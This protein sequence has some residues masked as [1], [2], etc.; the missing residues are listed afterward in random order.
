MRIFDCVI[1]SGELDL[2]ER[3]FRE[4][5]DIPEVTHVIAESVTDYKGNPK[6]LHFRANDDRFLPWLGRWNHVRVEAGELSGLPLERKEALRD[7]LSHGFNGEP[8]D[9]IM[10]SN[11]DEIPSRQAVRELAAGNIPLPVTLGMRWGED[12]W[13]GT[14]VQERQHTG[15]FAGLRRR[16]KDLPLLRDAGIRLAK[17]EFP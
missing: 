10:I 11:I 15:S 7:Y 1:L 17:G 16:R 2:L 9:L 4:L 12:T 14:V 6:L 13:H 3:R 8:R 5:A